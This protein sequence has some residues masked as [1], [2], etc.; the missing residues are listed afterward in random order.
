MIIAG[1]D[2]GGTK[3]ATVIAEV[4]QEDIKI[5]SRIEFATFS[6]YQ[7]VINQFII[8]IKKQLNELSIN[9][10]E[11]IGISCGGP[12]DEKKGIIL[13]PPNLLDW[14]NVPI[15]DIIS[16]ELGKKAKLLNDANAS[17]LAEWKY[18]A[19]KGY[20]NVVFLTFGTGLGA[21]LILNGSLY[22][23]ASGMAGEV[24]H[25]RLA[26]HGPIGYGKRGSFEGFC[27]GNGI[28][29]QITSYCILKKQQGYQRDW[30][31]YNNLTAKDLAQYANAGDELAIE[32]F[33]EVGIN[34]GKGLSII[35]DI[36]NP[37]IIVA[38]GIYMRTHQWIDE[39]MYESL[40]IETLT[41]NLEHVK[42][43][44]SSLGEQIGDYA[45]ICAG[46]I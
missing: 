33:K 28:K 6:S 35:I 12:L 16:N 7:E 22:T 10:V 18:G 44:P 36:L 5:L 21:G 42:I 26:E 31:N 17:A 40:K 34:F 13:A 32:F 19:A 20:N 9:E 29:Q 8:N 14:I 43:V 38:G 1:I 2:I 41:N 11:R 39:G 45:C 37:E 4:N 23:G 27:S 24:G 15:C 3:C 46:L 30:F 25:I